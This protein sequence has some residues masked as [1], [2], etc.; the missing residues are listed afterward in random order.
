MSYSQYLNC[1]FEPFQ[2]GHGK[3]SHMSLTFDSGLDF[4]AQKQI[5]SVF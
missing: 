2:D 1:T 3:L 5:G 4:L